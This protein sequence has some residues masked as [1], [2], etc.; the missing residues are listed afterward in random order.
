MKD[1]GFIGLEVCKTDLAAKIEILCVTGPKVCI[2][3]VGSE[4]NLSLRV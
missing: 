3:G 2:A 4:R 1:H